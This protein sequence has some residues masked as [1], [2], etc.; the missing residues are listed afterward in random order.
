MLLFLQTLKS[1]FK[2]KAQ[3]IIFII[4]A[5]ILTLLTTSSWIVNTRLTN[6]YSFMG[7][8]TFAYDYLLRFDSKKKQ[9]KM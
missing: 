8:G 5:A 2:Q 1:M 7:E 9:D 3:L 4:L 6:A